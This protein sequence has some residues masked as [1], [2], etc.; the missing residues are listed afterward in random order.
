MSGFRLHDVSVI[1]RSAA[2]KQNMFLA[3]ARTPT[4]A[5]A[6][7]YRGNSSTP[8]FL[9]VSAS[10]DHNEWVLPKGHIEAAEQP[11]DTATREVFEE[12]GVRIVLVSPEE[13]LGT[14]CYKAGGESVCVVFF[15]ARSIDE[16]TPA[17][18]RE[19]AWLPFQ[20]AE[21]VL[22][23]SESKAVLRQAMDRLRTRESMGAP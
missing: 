6:V 10:R 3:R 21:E 20:R 2:T 9:L 14:S 23:H 18:H 7:V 19:K 16:R 8:E 4:H 22:K 11:I 5:G 12:T 1:A 13:P 15:L 17:E